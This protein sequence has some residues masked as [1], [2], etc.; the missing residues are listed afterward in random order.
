MVTDIEYSGSYCT[1]SYAPPYAT[2][3]RG[4]S[5]FAHCGI[6]SLIH[7]TVFS[8]YKPISQALSLVSMHDDSLSWIVP[9]IFPRFLEQ[10]SRNGRSNV[11]VQ[12]LVKLFLRPF[13][14]SR[15][16]AMQLG[17]DVDDFLVRRLELDEVEL[18]VGSFV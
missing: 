1:V 11:I 5:E 3:F 6:H 7:L 4:L 17:Q 8:S 2:D 14:E 15:C 12:R 10:S 18:L 16:S 9:C 13:D